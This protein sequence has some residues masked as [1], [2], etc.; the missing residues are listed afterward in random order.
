V[1]V[2]VG[3]SGHSAK[4]KNA[5]EHLH[6]KLQGYVWVPPRL[7]Y[8]TTLHRIFAYIKGEVGCTL[9]PPLSS[10]DI[11]VVALNRISPLSQRSHSHKTNL[12]LTE[13]RNTSYRF[14]TGG[15]FRTRRFNSSSREKQ[16]IA[17]VACCQR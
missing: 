13:G 7:L 9:N 4:K 10:M 11:R 14:S 12:T 5:S 1:H 15:L 3:V 6:E 17:H 16:R 8:L 2:S